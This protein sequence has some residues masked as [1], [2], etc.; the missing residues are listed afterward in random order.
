MT[1]WQA[2]HNKNTEIY[3]QQSRQTGQ[4][5][6]R[7]DIHTIITLKKKAGIQAVKQ[8]DTAITEMQSNRQQYTDRQAGKQANRQTDIQASRLAQPSGRANK[9]ADS[10][11]IQS[12]RQS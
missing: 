8:T 2:T 7:P 3:R 11:I 4:E 9:Q 10:Q 6:R 12:G 1:N 5:Y